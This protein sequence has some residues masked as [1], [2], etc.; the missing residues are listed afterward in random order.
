M[1]PMADVIVGIG[2]HTRSGKTSIAGALAVRVGLP[3][4]R[5][6][7]EVERVALERGFPLDLPEVRRTIL[8]S[9]GEELAGADPEWFCRRVLAQAGWPETRSLIVEGVRHA[10]VADTLERL[11]A[12]STF[13]LV[14]V[15][16]PS[17]V[18]EARLAAEGIDGSQAR[19]RLDGHSTER[20]VDGALRARSDLEV[21][22]TGSADEAAA[23]IEAAMRRWGWASPVA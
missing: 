11:V 2:G 22:G 12:P 18:R 14:L 5:F 4:A 13:R 23:T 9:V 6:S 8:M 19:A 3:L 16:T 17:R 15:D 10:G 7:R 1:R 21:E 20:D